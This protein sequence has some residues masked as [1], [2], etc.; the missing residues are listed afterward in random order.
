MKPVGSIV[1]E[2]P[3]HLDSPSVDPFDKNP[4]AHVLSTTSSASWSIPEDPSAVCVSIPFLWS[5][6]VSRVSESYPDPGCPSSRK[7]YL[8]PSRPDRLPFPDSTPSSTRDSNLLGLCVTSPKDEKGK[9]S[10][11]HKYTTTLT[12]SLSVLGRGYHGARTPTEERRRTTPFS[13][14]QP[15][16]LDDLQCPVS[17]PPVTFPVVFLTF[18]T[19]RDRPGG[20]ARRTDKGRR[21][22]RRSLTSFGPADVSVVVRWSVVSCRPLWVPIHSLTLPYP[23]PGLLRQCGRLECPVRVEKGWTVGPTWTSGE[24]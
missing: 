17:V 1:S 22:V 18:R 5:F 8:P 2:G 10:I 13:G 14:N 19:L 4:V 16:V 12:M 21:L 7:L 6:R 9:F 15:F 23:S 11:I 20:T 24:W 3:G